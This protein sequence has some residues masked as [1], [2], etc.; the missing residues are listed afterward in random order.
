MH[1]LM[2]QQVSKKRKASLV[3]LSHRSCAA[4]ALA[5]KLQ[6][7]ALQQ[8]YAPAPELSSDGQVKFYELKLAQTLSLMSQQ[9]RL[10]SYHSPA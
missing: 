9:Q 1:S 2:C 5:R 6:Q 4:G 7:T 10:V 3:V 8:A